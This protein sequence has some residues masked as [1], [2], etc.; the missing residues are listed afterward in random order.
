LSHLYSYYTQFVPSDRKK[1]A[2]YDNISRQRT[3]S[4]FDVF[5]III[6]LCQIQEIKTFSK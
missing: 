3:E 2:H 4:N 5:G 6:M 1:I